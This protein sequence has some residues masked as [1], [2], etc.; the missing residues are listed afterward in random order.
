MNL[1]LLHVSIGLHR[2][3]LL[4]LFPQLYRRFL[5]IGCETT[6]PSALAYRGDDT[7]TDLMFGNHLP[8]HTPTYHRTD[9]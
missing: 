3:C 2:C 8:G 4:S 9:K 6:L 7:F 1:Y 5:L